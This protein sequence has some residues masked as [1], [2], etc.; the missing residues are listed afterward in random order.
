MDLK[1]HQETPSLPGPIL[2]LFLFLLAVLVWPGFLGRMFSLD[3]RLGNMRPVAYALQALLATLSVSAMLYRRQ[4]NRLY[5]KWF[6]TRKHLLFSLIAFS[7]SIGFSVLALEIGL[8]LRHFPFTEQLEVPENALAQFDPELGWVYIPNHTVVQEFGSAR[9]K[10]PMYFDSLGCRVRAPG[11]RH[12]PAAPSVLFVGDS[13]TFGHG[14]LYEETFA[15]QLEAMP[16]FPYQVV[17]L[18]VQGY[19]TDQ[20]LLLLK[21]QFHKFNTKFVVYTYIDQHPDRNRVSDERLFHRFNRFV[22]TK[23]L[24]GLRSDGTLYLEQAPVRYADLRYSRLWACIQIVVL[25]RGPKTTLDLTRALVQEMRNYVESK[26]AVFVVVHWDERAYWKP[27]TNPPSTLGGEPPF[28][29]MGLN[30]IDTTADLPA[31][32]STWRIPG[33]GHPDARAHAYV[34]HLLFEALVHGH[35]GSEKP[36]DR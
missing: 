20:A 32:W 14:L 12:D 7:C 23:P 26:G 21:R 4:I 5:A 28:R 33:D 17:N 30:L 19:G 27:E 8:R 24:F 22:G 18:G 31:G 16:G 34:S 15:G 36:R 25:R 13:F 2:G 9:R 1:T 11:V 35:G 6:P 10:V 29:G 3:W